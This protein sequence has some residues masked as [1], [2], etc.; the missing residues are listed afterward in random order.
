MY[1]RCGESYVM[2]VS[3]EG[4]SVSLHAGVYRCKNWE[5]EKCRQMKAKKYSER[6]FSIFK[7]KKVRFFTVTFDRSRSCEDTW[8]AAASCWNTFRTAMVKK[9]GKTTYVR[10]V[11]PQPKSGYPHFHILLDRYLP[12]SWITKELKLSGFGKIKDIHLL[13]GQDAFYYVL[14]YLKKPWPKNKGTEYAKRYNI[15]RYNT[16]RTDALNE[17][18]P[19]RFRMVAF[20]QSSKCVDASMT[21]IVKLCASKGVAFAGKREGKTSQSI[22]GLNF[23]WL[24]DCRDG[25][26]FEGMTDFDRLYECIIKD[27][28]H[29]IPSYKSFGVGDKDWRG[30]NRIAHERGMYYKLEPIA[31]L[32]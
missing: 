10:V 1:I 15:R 22:N 29:I 3:G 30:A 27:L 19:R 7:G 17:R 8:K 14:K 16:S 20:L 25:P 9:I 2:S 4:N 6:T 21:R 32:A 12:A 26:I 5:C 13:D 24:G 23:G 31:G 18:K 28:Y 11:E